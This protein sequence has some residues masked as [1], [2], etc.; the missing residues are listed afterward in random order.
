MYRY[1]FKSHSNQ[2]WVRCPAQDP[3]IIAALLKGE[4]IDST[5]SGSETRSSRIMR[6]YMK[7]CTKHFTNLCYN[8]PVIDE[9]LSVTSPKE[10]HL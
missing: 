2:V 9:L 4:R 6:L 8:P 3:S 5:S 1:P 7:H 10:Y